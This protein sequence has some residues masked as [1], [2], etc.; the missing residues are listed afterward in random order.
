MCNSKR[1]LDW[2]LGPWVV[3]MLLVLSPTAL[4]QATDVNAPRNKYSV[5]EDV[6]LGREAA[7]QVERQF[8]LLPER[9]Y[10]DNYVERVGGRLVRAIP[11]EFRHRQF[12][13]RFDVVNAS[14]INAFALPGGPLYVNRGLINAARSEGELAGV[15]A[16]EVAHIALRH[17]TAQA[18]EAQSAKFSLP[19]IGGA[20][21]GAIVGGTAGDIISAGTQFGLSTYFLKYSREYEEQADILGAQIMARAGY[22]PRDLAHMFQTIERRGGG[23]GPE[24]LSSHPDPENRYERINEEASRLN[25]N[26]SRATQNTAA[27]NRAQRELRRLP[28]APTTE[29][30]ARGRGR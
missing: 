21:L 4:A 18:T 11:Q 17:G 25:V 26:Y 10:V 24:F 27:F 20:I 28:P 7:A 13:Y 29:Q 5:A 8:P 1:R 3:I 23:G 9:G 2:P 6:R 15:L 30:I 16:H 19:A 14:D 12:R 22:D